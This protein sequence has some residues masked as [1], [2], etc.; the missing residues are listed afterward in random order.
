MGLVR[1]VMTGGIRQV[2]SF[3]GIFL[4]FII[5]AK[6]T[7][8]LGRRL[9]DGLGVSDTLAPIL[10]FAL[11]FLLIQGIAYGLARLLE[12]FLQGHQAGRTG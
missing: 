1:G 8:W 12:K 3:A 6:T 10:G 9:A 2:L 7:E 11:V 5:A 4:A